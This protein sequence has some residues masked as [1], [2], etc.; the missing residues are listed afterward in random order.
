[1]QKGEI[2]MLTITYFSATFY[3]LE[4]YLV[5]DKDSNGQEYYLKHRFTMFYKSQLY[6][7]S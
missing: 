3:I 7:Y 2:S 5:T 1:M 6:C 4:E